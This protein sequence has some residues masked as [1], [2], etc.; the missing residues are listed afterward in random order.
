MQTA[1]FESTSESILY[2]N[3]PENFMRPIS[4]GH[5]GHILFGCI[6]ILQFQ[7]N[8]SL[9]ITFPTKSCPRLLLFLRY[10]AAFAYYMI[11]ENFFQATS[12][13]Q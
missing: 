6:V 8:K 7:F 12:T 13:L 10:F 9:W 5:I 4:S 2:I 11:K 1:S 3:I